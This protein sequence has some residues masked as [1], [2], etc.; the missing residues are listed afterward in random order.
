M[1]GRTRRSPTTGFRFYAWL[2]GFYPAAHRAN[3]GEQMMRTFQDSYLDAY[4]AG[5]VRAGFWLGVIWDESRSILREHLTGDE[6]KRHRHQA[7]VAAIA[8]W[9]ALIVFGPPLL[10]SAAWPVLLFL[11][12]PWAGAFLAAPNLPRYGSKIATLALLLA[13]SGVVIAVGQNLGDVPDLA[14][15]LLM[16]ACILL[17]TKALAGWGHADGARKDAVWTWP[18]PAYGVMLGIL[19]S[20]A[21]ALGASTTADNDGT[22]KLIFYGVIPLLGGV[23]GIDIGRRHRSWIPATQATISTLLVA[24]VVWLLARPVLLLMATPAGLFDAHGAP[25]YA[26]SGWRHDI[27]G[28]LLINAMFG[29][30]GAALGLLAREA[31][32]VE[33]RA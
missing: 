15:P 25:M 1:P 30:A 9:G 28:L 12:V 20:F 7:L 22:V 16:V 23:A 4:S 17:S 5:G 10:P 32:D 21:L 19:G 8:L 29:L 27:A 11:T 3:Y 14:A 33:A 6:A 13:A 26:L 18:E 24:A 2:I 31:R